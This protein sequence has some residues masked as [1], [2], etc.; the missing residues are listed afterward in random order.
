LEVKVGTKR[1]G[2]VLCLLFNRAGPLQGIKDL[3][4]FPIFG[5]VADLGLLLDVCH[6]LLD[7][8]LS[9]L[10]QGYVQFTQKQKMVGDVRKAPAKAGME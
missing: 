10:K 2:I 7:K 3:L 6:P 4:L 1:K 5:L 9:F 8:N